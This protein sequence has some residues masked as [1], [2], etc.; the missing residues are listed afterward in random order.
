MCMSAP[1]C[2]ISMCVC[3]CV[4][5]CARM[6]VCHVKYIALEDEARVYKCVYTLPSGIFGSGV[7]KERFMIDV[8][9]IIIIIII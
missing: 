2:V 5:V 7:G 9:I 3:V 8:Y 1:V 6:S 4:C